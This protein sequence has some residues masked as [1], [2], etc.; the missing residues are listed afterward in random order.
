MLFGAVSWGYGCAEP[1]FYGV[2]GRILAVETWVEE[3]VGPQSSDPADGVN[4]LI[5][6]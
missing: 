1:E 2:Y 3:I 6:Q 5:N 4:A